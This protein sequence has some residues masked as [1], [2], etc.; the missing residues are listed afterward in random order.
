MQLII[1]GKD[2]R[3]GNGNKNASQRPAC[4]NH[5]VKT[6][7]ML[8]SGPEPVKL[9]MTNHAANKQSTAIDRH[10]LVERSIGSFKQRPTIRN[11][12]PNQ[13][14][15]EREPRVPPWVIKAN[16]ETQQVQRE[17][18]DPKEGNHRDV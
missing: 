7:Q 14:E 5:Q 11:H 10:L 18:Q 12:R 4:R 3:R 9:T 15:G 6:G 2:M 1:V 17:R 8:W 16:D 13:G